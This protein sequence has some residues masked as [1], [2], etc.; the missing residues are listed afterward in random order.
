MAAWI[1]AAMLAYTAGPGARLAPPRARAVACATPSIKD[2]LL[3]AIGSDGLAASPSVEKQMELNERILA[4]SSVN[5]TAEPA[6][7][8]LLNGRWEIIFAGAPASG[9]F[10]R[11]R[12][13]CPHG[14]L[15]FCT[16]DRSA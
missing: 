14:M 2:D 16:V 11:Y 7:S 4:L 10:L 1:A 6:R 15:F 13:G 12:T 3:Q 5:P 9:G 8:S